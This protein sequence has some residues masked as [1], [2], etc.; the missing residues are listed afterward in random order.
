M[1]KRCSLVHD[2][3]DARTVQFGAR[4]G[5][6]KNSAVWC[7][8]RQR[9]EQC[10]LVNDWGRDDIQEQCSLVN[11]SGRGDMQE[12][13]NL[14]NDWGRVTCNN[15]AGWSMVEGGHARTVQFGARVGVTCKNSAVCG[16]V[17]RTC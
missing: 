17:K 5:R 15:N 4:L 3:T 8:V 6:C 2:W 12:Q 1:L 9:Q 16:R 13:C 11:D 14:V 7:T 10:N